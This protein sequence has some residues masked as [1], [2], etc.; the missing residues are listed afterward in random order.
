MADN[1]KVEPGAPARIAPAL[2]RA[3]RQAPNRISSQEV[4]PPASRIDLLAP[5][6]DS[7][8]TGGARSAGVAPK[9]V[10]VVPDG[11][12]DSQEVF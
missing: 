3:Q 10:G 2:R 12:R 7:V 8:P 6:S 11:R 1:D 4:R 9:P 5:K